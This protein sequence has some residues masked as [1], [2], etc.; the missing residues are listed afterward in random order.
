MWKRSPGP[1]T[2]CHNSTE[3]RRCK[4]AY[5]SGRCNSSRCWRSLDRHRI[6][7][8]AH[9]RHSRGDQRAA[10]GLD[11]MCSGKPCKSGRRTKTSERSRRRSRTR[12]LHIE[13]R[14]PRRH[15][16]P[17]DCF[18]PHSRWPHRCRPPPRPRKSSRI[19]CRKCPARSARVRGV[20]A[21]LTPPTAFLMKAAAA[22]GG[23]E[24]LCEPFAALRGS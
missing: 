2:H 13:S 16:P 17:E 15:L 14:A 4:Q 18:Q 8:S 24:I 20:G 5:K 22:G 10:G 23:A 1:C 9:T 3:G 12:S 21:L 19:E 11:R 7:S 6:A